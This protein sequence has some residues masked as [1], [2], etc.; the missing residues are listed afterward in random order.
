MKKEDSSA[1]LVPLLALV[2]LAMGFFETEWPLMKRL[3]KPGL[4][5]MGH[6]TTFDENSLSMKAASPYELAREADTLQPV[7]LFYFH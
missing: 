7:G 6:P 3:S 2:L 5:S 4:R 1:R